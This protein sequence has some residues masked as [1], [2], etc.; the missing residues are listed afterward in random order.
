VFALLWCAFK[1][2][3]KKT[4]NGA[5]NTTSKQRQH[6]YSKARCLKL[7]KVL[8]VGVFEA[9]DVAEVHQNPRDEVTLVRKRPTPQI[10]LQSQSIT[11][12]TSL[13]P[14]L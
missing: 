6:R 10:S 14:L 2:A 4:P 8:S 7:K 11:N 3:H 5:Q 13:I 12:T 9:V 1:S